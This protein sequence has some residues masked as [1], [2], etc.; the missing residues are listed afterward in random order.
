MNLRPA[1]VVLLLTVV[2]C[3]PSTG[4]GGPEECGPGAA[5]A[6]PGASASPTPA[7]PRSPA[8]AAPDPE[9][10]PL[11]RVDAP[12]GRF[13]VPLSTS[14]L[15]AGDDGLQL[16]LRVEYP[17]LCQRLLGAHVEQTATAV[18][19]TA[20]GESRGDGPCP[21]RLRVGRYVVDLDAPLSGRAVAV[22]P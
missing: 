12:D 2:G 10:E 20:V 17:D 14:Y 22:A 5:C 7:V 3:G 8:A 15:G 21:L 6:P 4:S 19:V 11:D 9:P 1:G 13:T 18:T 16:T